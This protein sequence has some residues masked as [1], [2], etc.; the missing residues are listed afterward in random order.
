MVNAP[1]GKGMAGEA[2]SGEGVVVA[3][4]L[5]YL[6]GAA[7]ERG[8]AGGGEEVA[9]AAIGDDAPGAHHDDA[10]DFGQD[11]GQ[12]MGD[13]EESSTLVGEA[14]EDFAKLM[15]GAEVESVG[16]LVEEEHLGGVDEGAGDLNAA[17]FAGGHF[18]EGLGGEVGGIEA[19]EGLGGAESHLGRGREVGPEGGA[20]EEGGDDGVGAGRAERVGA[21]M[22]RGDYAEAAAEVFH[23]PALTAEDAQAGAR[24]REGIAL[25]GED[26]EQGGFAA[27]V[28]AE[29]DG[30]FAAGE[31]EGDVMED[32]GVA[33][34]GVEVAEFGEEIGGGGGGWL[35]RTWF[36]RIAGERGGW[37]RVRERGRRR[38]RRLRAILAAM[39]SVAWK[40]ASVGL[41]PLV[42]AAVMGGAPVSAAAQDADAPTATV[43]PEK[44]AET[45]QKASS[46]YDGRRRQLLD[47]VNRVA[48]SG[49][50]R[51]DWESLKGYQAPEWYQD[52][53]FG[54][55]IHWGVYSVPAFGSEWYPRLMY[56]QGSPEYEHQIATYGPLTK[57]GY[58]DFIPMFKAEHYDPQAWAK[59]FKDAG[60]RYVVP[61]F[62]HHDG[63]AM[64]D[65]GLSDWTAVKMGPHRDLWGDLAKAVR[66]EG[67]HL[68]ASSHRVEHDWFLEHGR[69][70]PS[71][72]NDPKYA[73]FYGPAEKRLDDDHDVLAEDWTYASPAYLQDW[74]ARDAEIVEKYHPEVIYF[75][76]WIGQPLVRRYL[77]EFAAFY[78]NESSKQGPVGVINYK[79]M[80]M[81]DGSAVLDVER[82]E[83][84]DIRKSVWQTDT[85]VSNKSW[86]YIK[87]D[88]FKSPDFLVHMLV[89]VVSKN[90]NLLLNIGPRSDG[91]IPEEVQQRLLAVGGWLKVN[92]EAIYGTR[93]W[94]VYG[95]GPTKVQSGSFND[96]KVQTYTPQDFRFTRKGA[97]LYAIE[98]AWPSDGV[99]TIHSLGTGGGGNEKVRSVT[100]LGANTPVKFTQ[101]ADGLRLE[102]PG[103]APGQYA[104]A[105]RIELGD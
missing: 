24:A 100:L 74:L 65:S 81:R 84:S 29:D 90:G 96:T 82:G 64:Y 38:G 42:L 39:K 58:K 70:E 5:D 102:V 56:T 9:L 11:V 54:I 55:F 80:D 32:D 48:N 95:E 13:E 57:F 34:G 75:D 69:L 2:G 77:T 25:A 89:D 78:Y 14:A 88:T 76:W 45:W 1:G 97:T 3:L 41:A 59:L 60:A 61:V 101:G 86:G 35:H 49:P 46:A 87:N 26:F 68:G 50:F 93:A 99:A 73:A 20:R 66:A 44:L 51:P 72:V 37:L 91:T 27:A 16:W 92:G 53:K 7:E 22:V 23:G 19:V 52:A 36:Q 10:V 30:M 104:Y 63:F 47:D 43:A 8:E 31:G 28:G 67:L 12:V 98:M 94:R 105:Y 83:L 6:D 15:L 79:E 18:A 4:A 71:D 40:N 85:S 33:A 17:E 103:Q 62:E 21:G